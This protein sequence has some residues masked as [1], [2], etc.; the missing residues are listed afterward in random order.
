MKTLLPWPHETAK[1][2]VLRSPIWDCTLMRRLTLL[3]VL[4]PISSLAA[5][6]EKL[7]RHVQSKGHMLQWVGHL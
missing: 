2:E 6:Q 4:L 1:D 7:A 5:R 3:V